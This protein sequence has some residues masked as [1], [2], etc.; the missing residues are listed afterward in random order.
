MF[1]KTIL[2]SAAIL[3]TVSLVGCGTQSA[4]TK[5]TTGQTQQASS[6]TNSGITLPTDKPAYMAKVASVANGQITIN[7]AQMA[8]A[9]QGTQ[10]QG[11][12]NQ[13]TNQQGRRPFGGFNFSS[14]TDTITIPASA[15]VATGNRRN[16]TAIKASDIKQGQIIQVWETNNT[17]SFVMVMQNNGNRSNNGAQNQQ[18]GQ[19]PAASNG[20]K[21]AQ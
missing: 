21:Q 3:A 1:K 7:K 12:Q 11:A 9:P 17:I 4:T 6:Q 2:V 19:Q 8:A 20:N 10:N 14:Q 18:G 15:K 16:L 13:G 5:S